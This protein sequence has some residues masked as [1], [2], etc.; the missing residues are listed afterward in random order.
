MPMNAIENVKID[1]VVPL[2]EIAPTL[3]RLVDQPAGR[4]PRPEV[5]EEVAI[6]TAIA[7]AT[8]KGISAREALEK[9]GHPST[10]TCPEC[11]GPLWELRDGELIRFRC[12]VGHSFNS[13]SMLNGQQDVVERALWMALG[14]IESRVSL[15]RRIAARM[16]GPHLQHLAR[17]YQAREDTARKDLEELR[18]IL[19]R[20]G[21]V[22]E[23]R[24][25]RGRRGGSPPPAS[26][27]SGGSAARRRPVRRSR[28][29]QMSRRR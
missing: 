22:S 17:F 20:N 19:M 16:K 28:R 21:D 10:Y 9:V 5:S 29:P 7:K 1:H 12:Q 8:M 11:Q 18:R 26:E 23:G 24:G 14:A 6:E 15:W 27:A 2:T 25:A 3:L 13:E 4:R